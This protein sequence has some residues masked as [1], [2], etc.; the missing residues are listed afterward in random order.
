VVVNLR[1][2]RKLASRY[3][4]RAPARRRYGDWAKRFVR[5]GPEHD[6][7]LVIHCRISTSPGSWCQRI[8]G[9]GFQRFAAP[10][11]PLRCGACE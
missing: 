3:R 5:P 6:A 2:A 8:L 4:K 10:S 7:S 9:V 11:R 1:K